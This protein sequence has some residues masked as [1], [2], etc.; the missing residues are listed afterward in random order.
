MLRGPLPWRTSG[1][2]KNIQNDHDMPKFYCMVSRVPFVIS[3][4]QW[5]RGSDVLYV[6]GQYDVRYRRN[7]GC[8]PDLNDPGY[9]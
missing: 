3:E 2:F 4:G 9:G 6:A 1:V 7:G 5:I 8:K